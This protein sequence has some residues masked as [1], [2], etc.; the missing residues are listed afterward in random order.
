MLTNTLDQLFDLKNLEDFGSL[1]VRLASPDDIRRWSRGEVTKPETINYRTLKSEKDGLFDEKIFGPTKDWECFCGKY[2][3]IRYKGVIC[4]KCGV[5]VTQSRVR[6]ERMGHI[7][8]ACP[9]AHIWFF[10]GA[11]SKISTIL[12][13]APRAIEQVIYFARYL[14][15]NVDEDKK[16]DAIKVLEKE[17]AENESQIIATFKEKRE[18]LV[19]EAK[20]AREKVETKIK[21]KDQASLAVS[22]IELENRKKETSLSEDEKANL[23]RNS[24]LFENLLS[25]VRSLKTLSILSEEEY[26]ELSN[27]GAADFFDSKMG[28]EAVLSVL[29]EVDIEKIS[30]EL[31]TEVNETKPTSTKYIKLVKRLKLVEGLKKAKIDPAWMILRVLPV[32]PPDLRPM[33]QLSGGRFATSD[34]NDLYRRVINRNNRLKHLIGLGAPEIILRNEKRMLQEAV[35]SLIDASQRKATRRARGRQP[36]RSLSDML[37]GKQGRFRQNLLGKRVDYSGRSVI[38]VGPDLK[39]NQC[40]LPKEMA[41]EMF[42]P[43]VL[44]EMISRG[45][46]PNVKSAKNMLDRRP[47]EVFD[48]LEEIT[49]DHPVLLNRAPTLHKLSIQ[50]FYPI[51]IEGS[52]IRLHPAICSGFNADFDGDQMAVHVPLSKQAIEEAKTLML[53]EHNLLRPSDGSPVSTPA[54]KEMALGIYYLTSIDTKLEKIKTIFAD[55]NEAILAH[56]TERIELRQMID[57]RIESKIIETTVGRIYLNEILPP[58]FDYVNESGTSSL[59]K[60]LFATAYAKCDKGTVVKMI[61]DVKT[62][63]FTSGTISG[64]SFGVFDAV[65]L[66]EKGK[67]LK[68]AEDK[69]S[70]IEANFNLGLITLEEKKRMTKEVWLEVSEDLADKTWALMGPTNPIRVVIDAKVGRASRDQVKQLSAMRGLVVDPL[71]KIVELPIKSNFREGL[72]VFEYVTSS[73]GSRKGL[74]D[75]AIKT[76]DAGYLTRRL[77]DVSHDLIIRYNDCKTKDGLKVIKSERPSSFMQRIIGRY[78]INDI[79]DAK[80]K[81][82]A[83]GGDLINEEIAGKIDTSGIDNLEVRSALT[84]QSRYGLC[85][86]CYGWDL[87][88]KNEVLMGTPVGVIA[89]QSIGEPGTQLTLKT[90]H[91]AGAFG[92]LDVTQGL[93]RV[94]ELV[95]ARTPKVVSSIAEI[96]GKAIVSE[97]DDGYKVT[98]RGTGKIKEEREYIVPKTLELAVKDNQIVEAGTALAFGPLDLKEILTIKGLRA[99][100]EY[101]VAEIQKVYESQ[102]IG[103]NDKHFEVIARKMSDEIRIIGSGDTS[104]LPG[105]LTSKASFEAANEKVLVEGG[106]PASASQIILGIT[107]RSLYTESWLSAASFEQTTDVLTES[108]LLSREDTLMGLKENVIIGRLIPVTEEKANLENK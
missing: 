2:K 84:C 102:G 100:Q 80:N 81:V 48:I 10:K 71:G 67:I 103:I 88:T 7:S 4:D 64:I 70:E 104:F 108:S 105:E 41:L 51:L 89:A 62:L 66:P 90:K 17:L 93:P 38:I 76:A 42:K 106:E 14:A 32:L 12:G 13:V 58:V 75:T 35:D 77:V 28:A 19:E 56:Q 65:L 26:D 85:A 43:F 9:V 24:R 33:V 34:L 21:D 25:L 97:S 53:P 54:S 22:E 96:T 68:E 86:K 82:I 8:L 52:A 31:R 98:I 101:L 46:A 72:S 6:R 39:L 55:I 20:K 40:G 63:G 59:I 3:R 50:A 49:K 60:K 78:L 92:V 99:A 87:S 69:V 11:P 29:N 18:I 5:E 44:R 74:T 91:A 16:K 30:T 57:V 37:K 15:L 107:R 73:R 83:I 95:E 23:S 36:L 47:P 79:K 27:F 61:D 94:E 45:I 1:V